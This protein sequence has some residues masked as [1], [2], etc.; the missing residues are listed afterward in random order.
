MPTA[1]F[2]EYAGLTQETA[3]LVE[4]FRKSPEET[5]S[6]II[7][8]ILSPLRAP[9]SPVG[10][11]V[12]DLGQGAKLF[13]GEEL[14]LFLSE[15]AKRARTPHAVA[16]VKSGEFFMDGK[17]VQPSNRSVLQ[18][19]M[20]LVQDKLGHRNDKGE[21]I[22]L[23]A[24]RQW[25]VVRKGQLISMVELKDPSLARKRGRT[26]LLTTSKTADELGL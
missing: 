10:A 8:R 23:S 16:T 20:H 25:H 4:H 1:V 5:K 11:K 3:A 2:V 12:L 14:L 6:E 19:A 7:F 18:P 26:V 24:W 21:I 9:T 22:S 17:R 15:E 13:D